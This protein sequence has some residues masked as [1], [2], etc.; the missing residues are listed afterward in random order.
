MIGSL[1]NHGVAPSEIDSMGWDDLSYWFE[2]YERIQ[3]ANKPK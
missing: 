1:F 3:E 2:W